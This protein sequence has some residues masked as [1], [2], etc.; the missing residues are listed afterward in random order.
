MLSDEASFE[1]FQT[2][3]AVF[4]LE[5]SELI[6]RESYW[7]Y[8]TLRYNSRYP[9][10]RL[11]KQDS[12][13]SICQQIFEVEIKPFVSKRNTFEQNRYFDKE[14]FRIIFNYAYSQKI[15]MYYSALV[16]RVENY[17]TDESLNGE[18]G[19]MTQYFKDYLNDYFIKIETR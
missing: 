17:N 5:E 9:L 13:S 8:F 10:E 6:E 11:L 15:K 12:V 16:G 1:N 14:I 18:D 3:V 2:L 7:Y 19:L 4:C